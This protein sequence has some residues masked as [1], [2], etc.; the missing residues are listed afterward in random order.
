MA[1]TQAS[2]G[3]TADLN[4]KGTKT[5][6]DKLSTF[7]VQPSTN[8]NRKEHKEHKDKTGMGTA[9]YTK[10]ASQARHRKVKGGKPEFGHFSPLTGWEDS[11]GGVE[12]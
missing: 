12:G 9:K 2:A 5:R 11:L 6:R 8:L 3:Q 10:L 4:N 1:K 7:N